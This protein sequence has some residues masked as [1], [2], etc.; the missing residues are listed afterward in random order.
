MAY[1]VDSSHRDNISSQ[2]RLASTRRAEGG[3]KN[4][5]NKEDIN[6]NQEIELDPEAFEQPTKY[7]L[8]KLITGIIIILGL[9][10]YMVFLSIERLDTVI[11]KSLIYSLLYTMTGFLMYLIV[12]QPIFLVIISNLY[13]NRSKRSQCKSK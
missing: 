8:S 4:T 5:P 7:N 6:S 3:N 10:T 12:A 2:R 9:T 13:V 1:N 11:L